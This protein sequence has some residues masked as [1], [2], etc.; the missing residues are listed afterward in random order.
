MSQIPRRR[1]T[2]R[3]T[4]G[5]ALAGRE[6]F[7]PW[8]LCVER[9]LVCLSLDVCKPQIDGTAGSLCRRVIHACDPKY[10]KG[11]WHDRCKS[12]VNISPTCISFIGFSLP[13]LK[14]GCQHFRP[15]GQRRNNC[16]CILFNVLYVVTLILIWWVTNCFVYRW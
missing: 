12:Q 15:C 14:S 3:Y 11:P 9:S 6:S 7:W 10:R 2:T 1:R 8:F 13:C 4:R 5:S 16:C